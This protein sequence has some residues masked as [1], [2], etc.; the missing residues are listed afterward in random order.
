MPT[1]QGHGV[2]PHIRCSI[3]RMTRHGWSG[4]VRGKVSR[5]SD[6]LE[7]WAAVGNHHEWLCLICMRLGDPRDGSRHGR[8]HG[9]GVVVCAGAAARGP[10]PD[11]SG[12]LVYSAHCMTKGKS[13]LLSNRR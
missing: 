3:A 9:G 1:V 8:V 6:A 13:I 2:G 10:V 4:S 12:S 5:G 11:G 7:R